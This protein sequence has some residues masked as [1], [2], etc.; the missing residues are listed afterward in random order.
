MVAVFRLDGRTR[1]RENFVLVG[2]EGPVHLAISARRPVLRD[3]G[4]YRGKRGSSVSAILRIGN[5]NARCV[6][7]RVRASSSTAG[8]TRAHPSLRAGCR[9]LEIA[10]ARLAELIGLELRLRGELS[11]RYTL[12]GTTYG[13]RYGRVSILFASASPGNDIVFASN[14][15]FRP[16]R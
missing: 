6:L 10:I 13:L 5:A 8:A 1:F 11:A 7:A 16:S 4:V 3:P 9:T 12:S 15:S 2:H 14:F